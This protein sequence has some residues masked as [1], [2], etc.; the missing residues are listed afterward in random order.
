[1]PELS[2][3]GGVILKRLGE[4]TMKRILSYILMAVMILALAGCSKSAGDDSSKPTG[5][6]AGN[7]EATGTPT[8]T[9]TPAGTLTSTGILT[10]TGTPTPTP[11]PDT[12]T[13]DAANDNASEQE[14]TTTL[15]PEEYS[16]ILNAFSDY[17]LDVYMEDHYDDSFYEIKYAVGFVDED[18]IPELFVTDGDYH[19]AGTKVFKYIDGEVVYV[20][21]FG[22]SGGFAFTPRMNNIYSFFLNM[23]VATNTIFSMNPDGS[24]V[25]KGSFVWSEEYEDASDTYVTK[26]FVNEVETGEAEYNEA[27]GSFYYDDIENWTLQYDCNFASFADTCYNRPEVLQYMLDRALEGE[28]F[29]GYVTPEMEAMVGEWELVR[30]EIYDSESQIFGSF[31]SENVNSSLSV[32]DDFHTDFWLSAWENEEGEPEKTLFKADYY[33][34]MTYLPMAIYDGVENDEYSVRCDGSDSDVSY[35]LVMFTDDNGAETLEFVILSNFISDY[36]YD[37]TILAYYKRADTAKPVGT[38]YFGRLVPCPKHNRDDGTNAYLLY[39]NLWITCDTPSE[40]KAQYGLADDLDGY[41]YE[42]VET[43]REP[44]LVYGSIFKP[45]DGM[46]HY[47]CYKLLDYSTM[48]DVYTDYG[49]FFEKVDGTFDGLYVNLYLEEGTNIANY[50]AEAYTG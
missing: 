34:P 16:I 28:M 19:A 2:R 15:T 8:P 5:M 47:T 41:D 25:E 12:K 43:D 36:G 30:A 40:I 10:P 39:E 50:I 32:S 35:Y 13:D 23:G 6:P 11:S 48:Q 31:D 49:T 17:L 21:E 45:S 37:D 18:D 1:M 24:L 3:F 22:E 33:M 20:G 9:P 44:M 7:L 14:N 38:K 42:I 26:Y 29:T 4:G 27:I 46:R